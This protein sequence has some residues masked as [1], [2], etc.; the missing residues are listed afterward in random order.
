[1]T[2]AFP[3]TPSTTA[4]LTGR[5]GF[6]PPRLTQAPHVG[7]DIH[8]PEPLTVILEHKPLKTDKLIKTHKSRTL[9]QMEGVRQQLQDQINALQQQVTTGDY[10]TKK[11]IEF[12]AA[13]QQRRLELQTQCNILES[14]CEKS[15]IIEAQMSEEIE[16]LQEHMRRAGIL[17]KQ[18]NDVTPRTECLNFDAVVNID[19][20]VQQNLVYYN[21]CF[22]TLEQRLLQIDTAVEKF[23]EQIMTPSLDMEKVNSMFASQR[24]KENEKFKQVGLRLG[25]DMEKV[26]SKIQ[27]LEGELC[28][29]NTFTWGTRTQTDDLKHRLET[30]I[31][32]FNMYMRTGQTGYVFK[33]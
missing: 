9:A 28:N 23:E 19:R 6:P 30:M 17:A 1:M 16:S 26:N 20:A 32:G 10:K 7:I 15:S 29:M 3:T 8:R 11:L 31:A 12:A 25:F 27:Q 22:A 14:K 13:Q 18:T 33:P 2:S 24:E 21:Q 5:M 4:V